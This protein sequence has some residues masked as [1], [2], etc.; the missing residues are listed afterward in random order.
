MPGKWLILSDGYHGCSDIW[1]SVT[2]PAK[3]VPPE[4]YVK[5]LP[6]DYTE[7]LLSSACAVIIEPIKL[8]ASDTRKTWIKK[9]REDCTNYGVMLIFD[10]IVTGFRVSKYTVSAWWNIQPDLICLGKAL[11]NG[12]PL[13]VVSG[14]KE[15]MDCGEYFI[16]STYSGEAI[17]LAACKATLEE[18]QKRKMEDLIYYG[19]R[20]CDRF[21]EICKPIGSRI[22][23]YG[24]RGE[25]DF[26]E[27]DNTVLLF[28]ELCKCGILMGRAFFWNFAH[29]EEEVEES[30]LNLVS[31]AV[32][33]IQNGKVK[34]EGKKPIQSFKR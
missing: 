32:N 12:Y 7:E 3:G 11:A 9:L 25:T 4:Q 26:Y 8:D 6:D 30:T 17:S 19:Q 10:E 16:S 1:T 34:L 33:R 24:S 2:L 28:Q 23:G 27:N 21:N 22:E 13:A 18:L 20:F 29:I 31:D 15:V 5:Q 14:K